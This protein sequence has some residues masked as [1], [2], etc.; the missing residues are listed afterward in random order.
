[1]KKIYIIH[2]SLVSH[3]ELNALFAEL[4]PDTKVHNLIDDSLLFDVMQNGG[5]TS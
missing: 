4:I 3:A 5:I 2:T 1:M